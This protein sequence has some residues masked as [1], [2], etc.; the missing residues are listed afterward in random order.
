MRPYLWDF[1]YVINCIA[2]K[3]SN[4]ILRPV[5]TAHHVFAKQLG[6]LEGS[7]AFCTLVR[8]GGE[9][10]ILILLH[11]AARTIVFICPVGSHQWLPWKCFCFEASLC[12]DVYQ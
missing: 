1:F 2:F 10:F 3:S 7:R 4:H 11:L 9:A 6:R 8:V 5:M 12:T